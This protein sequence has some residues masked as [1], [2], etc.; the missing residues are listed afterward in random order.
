M[1]T[2]SSWEDLSPWNSTQKHQG[3]R[4]EKYEIYENLVLPRS[5]EGYHTNKQLRSVVEIARRHQKPSP[6]PRA[7]N[8]F[9]QFPTAPGQVAE[10]CR[11]VSVPWQLP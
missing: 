4:H 1:I 8:E 2:E 6:N 10:C 5:E 11:M 3:K 9:I 7:S